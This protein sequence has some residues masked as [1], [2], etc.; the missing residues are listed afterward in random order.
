MRARVS[1]FAR[2][3]TEY[4][5]MP[6]MR[7]ELRSVRTDAASHV[8]ALCRVTVYLNTVARSGA[9]VEVSSVADDMCVDCVCAPVYMYG[10]AY[11]R[12]SGRIVLRAVVSTISLSFGCRERR[13][14]RRRRRVQDVLNISNADFL[15]HAPTVI[16]TGMLFVPHVP[17]LGV[18][19][20]DK[21]S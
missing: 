19:R 2:T 20:D 7:A 3:Y 1:V 13:R 18:T 17:I 8:R 14:R 15:V 12:N 16:A 6:Y 10:R 11:S 5:R 21:R 9:G 4:T